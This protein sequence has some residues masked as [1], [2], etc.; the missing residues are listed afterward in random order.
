MGFS[1]QEYWGGLPLPSPGVYLDINFEILILSLF[2]IQYQAETKRTILGSEWL[3]YQC[4]QFLSW[5]WLFATPW[6]VA[7]Q[8]PLGSPWNFPG[9]H[10]EVGCHFLL[11]GIFPTQGLNPHHHRHLHSRWVLDFWQIAKALWVSLSSFIKGE[12]NPS[13]SDLLWERNWR[14]PSE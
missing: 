9:R 5:V 6:S 4:A 3:N 2:G 7:R 10:N 13:Y 11:Y 12:N 1:R 14:R 8:Y